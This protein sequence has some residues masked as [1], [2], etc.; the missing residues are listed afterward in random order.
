MVEVHVG[1]LVAVL[2]PVGL[3]AEVGADGDRQIASR[4][5]G[6][7]DDG[8]TVG[9]ARLFDADHGA[10]LI[11]EHA[12]NKVEDLGGALGVVLDG[13]S[14]AVGVESEV[15]AL[16][17]GVGVLSEG[18][19]PDFVGVFDVG[20]ELGVELVVE[21][22]GELGGVVVVGEVGEGE[23]GVESDAVGEFDHDFEWGAVVGPAGV[24]ELGAV[25]PGGLGGV[26]GVHPVHEAHAGVAA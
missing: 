15:E 19:V 4:S 20:G 16:V 23:P 12:A 8:F 14:V 17:A 7:G 26:V 24:G 13:G 22:G 6:A 9:R 10:E 3:E 25:W 2:G 18:G 5:E 21:Q 1:D 11:A